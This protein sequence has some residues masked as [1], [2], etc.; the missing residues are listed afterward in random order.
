M[1]VCIINSNAFCVED[2]ANIENYEKALN[3][4]EKYA[5]HHRLET[6]TS[7]GERRKV[8][9]SKEELIVL[10]VYYHRPASE[11]IYL[12][13][14]EH[15]SL[16]HKGKKMSD[17]AK[18]KLSEARI[19]V[20]PSN[21]GKAM[22]DGQKKELSEKLKRRLSPF[23]GKHHSDEAKRKLSE[24]H[25]EKKLS[26][27]HKRKISEGL[28]HSTLNK[29]K[30]LLEEQKRHLSEINT[31]SNNPNYGSHWKLVDGKRVYY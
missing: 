27:E 12:T 20:P 29:G 22:S 3:S 5:C 19:G 28:K 11:L 24:A 26:E 23:K 9:L 16:H 1:S 2:I 21:K 4:E 18:R 17:E 31:G 6:H 15:I 14:K 10:G 25:K 8:D 13:N 30:H 7:D